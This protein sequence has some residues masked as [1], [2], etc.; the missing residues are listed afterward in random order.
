MIKTDYDIEEY[1]K[2]LKQFSHDISSLLG[3]NS[4]KLRRAIHQSIKDVYITKARADWDKLDEW[5]GN[6]G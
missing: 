2:L 3:L 1:C 4:K 5:E 6:H